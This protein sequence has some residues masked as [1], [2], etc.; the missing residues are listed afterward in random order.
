MPISCTSAVNRYPGEY[1]PQYSSRNNRRTSL[2]TDSQPLP[3]AKLGAQRRGANDH[4]ATT[5][6]P[7]EHGLVRLPAGPLVGFAADDS[8]RSRISSASIYDPA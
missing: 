6:G 5:R 1:H 4:G 7:L 8:A 3:G 2:D